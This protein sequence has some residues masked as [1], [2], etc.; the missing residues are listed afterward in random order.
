MNKG[1]IIIYNTDD[2]QAKINLQIQDGTVWLNQLELAEL[3][4]TT[5][6]NISLH[7]KKIFVDGELSKEATVKDYLT[8][9]AEGNR[10]V[11]RKVAYYNLERQAQRGIVMTMQDWITHVDGVLTGTGEKLLTHAGTISTEQKDEKVTEEHKKYKQKTLSQVERDYLDS[12]KD[13]YQ[14]AKQGTKG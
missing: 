10:Q 13:V 3:F 14:L 11:S 6:N 2:N 1:Q 8:V 12:M 5:K 4:E 7:V 9:Q